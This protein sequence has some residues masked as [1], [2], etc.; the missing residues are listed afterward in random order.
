MIQYPNS[1]YGFCEECRKTAVPS[2]LEFEDG[3]FALV[4]PTCAE[5]DSDEAES[6]L[7]DCCEVKG[8]RKTAVTLCGKCG[9]AI[10]NFHENS[11]GYCDVCSPL[12][13]KYSS[14]RGWS[15]DGH[16]LKH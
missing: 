4:C 9:D 8:C 15:S 2:T 11:D 3:T 1:A 13:A 6:I 7:P 5:F 16:Y 14:S 12:P 10:C